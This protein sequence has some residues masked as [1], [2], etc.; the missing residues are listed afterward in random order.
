MA[1]CVFEWESEGEGYTTVVFFSANNWLG[2]F[3]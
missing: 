1:D 2:I 3:N